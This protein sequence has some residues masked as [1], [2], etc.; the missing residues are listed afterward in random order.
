MFR[1][2]T[3][4]TD[5]NDI[6]LQQRNLSQMKNRRNNCYHLLACENCNSIRSVCIFQHKGI[7]YMND[8][9]PDSMPNI[10]GINGNRYNGK[11]YLCG[12]NWSNC[13]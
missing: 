5:T 4:V 11:F 10:P 7:T 8:D 6:C 2:T 1:F 12:E 3:Y 9:F 13:D